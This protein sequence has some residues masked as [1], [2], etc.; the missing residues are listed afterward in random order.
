MFCLLVTQNA[1]KG[2]LKRILSSWPAVYYLIRALGSVEFHIVGIRSLP[3]FPLGS[4][5]LACKLLFSVNFEGFLF[6]KVGL[7]GYL[8][9]SFAY[10]LAAMT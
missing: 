5:W 4:N 8:F 9:V 2:F 1:I 10:I 3:F 6:A 7:I